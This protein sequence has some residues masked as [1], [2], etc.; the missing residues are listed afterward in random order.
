MKDCRFTLVQ[1][2]RAKENPEKLYP[3]IVTE[4][5]QVFECTWLR[6]LDGAQD[7]VVQEEYDPPYHNFNGITSRPGA[8]FILRLDKNYIRAHGCDP[9]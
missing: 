6:E 1:G 4:S 9:G 7:D 5:F 8:H 3:Q 2:A